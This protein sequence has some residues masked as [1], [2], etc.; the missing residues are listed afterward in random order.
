MNERQFITR[1]EIEAVR[2][3][4]DELRSYLDVIGQD[5]DLDDEEMPQDI[6]KD[7]VARL[8]RFLARVD[9]APT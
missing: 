2:V 7:V 1:K 6:L 9:G 5:A 4:V 8:D 3:S